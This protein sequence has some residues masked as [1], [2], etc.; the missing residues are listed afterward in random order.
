MSNV[1]EFPWSWFLGEYTQVL[2]EKEKIF[3][4]CL[5][6]PQNVKL[7]IITPYLCSDGNEMYKKAWWTCKVVVLLIK[8]I[9]FL[10]FS[11]PSPSSLLKLPLASTTATAV[12]TSLLKWIPVFQTLSRLFQFAENGKCRRISLELISW[13]PHSSL[14]R[15]KEI[16]RR[17][18]TFSRRSRA[19]TVKKCTKKRDARANLL[20]CVI[21]LLLFWRPGCRRRR[22]C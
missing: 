10:M 12:K 11:L 9:A 16:R 17:L 8:P 14:E 18:F 19:R 3:V 22:R 5:R 21:N 15:E 7:G 20:F 2:E 4:A 13:G 6:S 1:G